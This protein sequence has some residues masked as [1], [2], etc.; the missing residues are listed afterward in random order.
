MENLTPAADR[1]RPKSFDDIAGQTHL[2]GKNG[3]LRKI[4]QSGRL[5]SMIFFGPPGTGKT[6]CATILAE[7]S[8]MELRRL[9]ATTAS[10]SDIKDVAAETSGIFGQKGILLYLDEIQ[11]FNKKQQQSLL[12][13][14]EDGRIT[15][16]ASTTENPYYYIYDALLSRCS[17]FEFKPVSAKD[18]SALLR[19][20]V[21]KLNENGATDEALEYIARSAQGDVRRAIT[22]L[23]SASSCADGEVTLELVRQLTPSVMAGAFDRDGDV[24]YDLLSCLQKSIRGSDPD[25]AVF[26]LAKLLEGGD[27]ISPC[28]R[29]MVIASEDIGAAYP[30]AAVITRACIESARELGMPEA[31]IPL[32]NAAVMLATAPKSNSAYL[33]FDAASADIRD[34]KGLNIPNHL[35][36]PQFKGYVYPHDYPGHWTEQQYLPDDLK[37][38]KYYNF[39]DNKTEQAAKQYWEQIKGKKL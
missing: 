31:R 13:Y 22:M 20:N 29:L 30:M 33:A 24:H 4:S 36:S 37:T 23:D 1:L 32:A 39:G 2:V 6:T 19:R 12:E 28:R 38:R 3:I 15:L 26:Y 14:L 10:L 5:Q 7:G 16:I 25:A 11:Y 35:R 27:L 17:V 18:I 34:G 21:N 8:G 9:N